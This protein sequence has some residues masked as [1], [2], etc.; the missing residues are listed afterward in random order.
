LSAV[1]GI[2]VPVAPGEEAEVADQDRVGRPEDFFDEVTLEVL[3]VLPLD[4]VP[5]LVEQEVRMT[6]EVDLAVQEFV[7]FFPDLGRRIVGVAA[8]AEV[9]RLDPAV[10]LSGVTE[11]VL[12]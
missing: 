8:V 4:A 6:V 5:R 10:G 3:Q 7:Q 1:V 2:F 12:G 11:N 9:Q